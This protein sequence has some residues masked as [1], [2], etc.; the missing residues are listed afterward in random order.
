MITWLLCGYHLQSLQVLIL[1]HFSCCVAMCVWSL[2]FAMC[3]KHVIRALHQYSILCVISSAQ[4]ELLSNDGCENTDA[5]V[6]WMAVVSCCVKCPIMQ[7]LCRTCPRTLHRWTVVPMAMVPC[8]HAL[9]CWE[10]VVDDVRHGL[11]R[12]PSCGMPHN[13]TTATTA[14]VITAVACPSNS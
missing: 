6:H 2:V 13:G 12:C 11:D 8:G 10:C 1:I 7:P 3:F 14:R 4:G 9:F 5:G